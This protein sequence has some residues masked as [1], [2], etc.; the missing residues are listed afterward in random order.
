MRN[1]IKIR[2]KAVKM[3][4]ADLAELTSVTR[5]TIIAIENDKYDPSLQLAFK[6]AE[7][8]ETNVDELFI[9]REDKNE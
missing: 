3:S 6:L 1:T 4:Q 2:R 5:Q 9:F 8:L 7:A